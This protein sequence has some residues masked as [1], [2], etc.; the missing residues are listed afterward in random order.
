LIIGCV[1]LVITTVGVTSGTA[2][3]GA[4]LE[5]TWTQTDE[6]QSNATT[7]QHEHPD[8]VARPANTSALEQR[9]FV[10][11]TDRL[12]ASARSIEAGEYDTAQQTLADGYDRQLTLYME[13]YRTAVTADLERVEQRETLFSETAA[14]Q[15]QYANQLSEYQRVAGEYERAR[16]DD[17]RERAQQRARELRNITSDLRR[18]D[19]SLTPRYQAIA[20]TTDGSTAA[21]S[22]VVSATTTET[23]QQTTTR[24]QE[25]YTVTEVTAEASPAGSFTDPVRITGQLTAAD[26]DPPRGTVSFRV[27]GRPV[28]TAVDPNGTFVIPYRPVAAAEGSTQI[29]VRYVPGDAALYLPS[30]TVVSTTIN[31][32]TPTVTIDDAVADAQVGS[33]V[34][35][36]GRVTANDTPVSNVSVVLQIGDRTLAETRTDDAGTYQFDTQLP[37][38]VS[39]GTRTLSVSAGS[40]GTALI[41]ARNTTGLT[42]ERTLTQLTL[43]PDRSEDTVNIT[44]QLVAGDGTGVAG[45][46]IVVLL[47]GEQRTTVQTSADGRYQASVELSDTTSASSTV[48]V[49]VAFDGGDTNLGFATVATAVTTSSDG[50]LPADT[51]T[52]LIMIIA[53]SIT[54]PVSGFALYRSRGDSGST[55]S[56]PIDAVQPASSDPAVVATPVTTDG[57]EAES[58]AE[59]PDSPQT[60]GDS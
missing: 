28:T 29:S 51:R 23:T 6:P 52:L 45:Q 39:T 31:Q 33:P 36:A 10:T 35:A 44:G 2:N 34:T 21:A 19:E 50:A 60:E 37:S 43:S 59:P 15:A 56:V 14:L 11:L 3:T 25:S 20:E 42:I 17:D 5:T 49:R 53:G 1:L 8:S 22:R 26:N 32:S 48:V 4:Q 46:E 24:V 27:N 47:N 40:T 9:L 12:A 38:N 16:E 30:G 13:V 57:D 18:I 58:N 55:S 54:V 41:P 7:A